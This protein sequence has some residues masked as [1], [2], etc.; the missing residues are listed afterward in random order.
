MVFI[1]A[2]LCCAVLYC[3]KQQGKGCC[4]PDSFSAAS[5]SAAAV[6]L[7][8]SSEAKSLSFAY[9]NSS[10]DRSRKK[11]KQ[12]RKEAKKGSC[13]YCS[14]AQHSTAAKPKQHPF[15]CCLSLPLLCC[16]LLLCC[17]VLCCALTA[18]QRS[19]KQNSRGVLRKQGVASQQRI[20]FLNL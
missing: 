17:A 6:L 19:S 20:R 9:S 11:G 5:S 8:H 4:F 3:A 10:K 18:Q 7:Q 2:V 1:T 16:L 14:T 15:L 12:Q 13:L